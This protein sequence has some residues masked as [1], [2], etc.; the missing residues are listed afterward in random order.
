LTSQ[1]DEMESGIETSAVLSSVTFHKYQ[2]LGNDYI[3]VREADLR[4]PLAPTQIQRI[5]DRHYGFGADGI[6]LDCS[7]P[8][9]EFAARFFNPDGSEAEKSG[10][11]LRIYARYLWD[12]KRVHLEPFT[13]VTAG[14][15]VEAQVHAGG[16]R[17]TVMMG[18][19]CFDS[20]DIPVQGPPREVLDETIRIGDQELT[21]SAVT[22]GNP[23]CVLLRDDLSA[24]E[25]QQWGALLENEPRFP[26]RT[27]VQFMKVLDRG[28]IQIEIWERGAGYT[29]ASGSSSCAAAVVAYRLG[30]CDGGITV[31]MPGGEIEI[32]IDEGYKVSMTGLVAKVWQGNISEEV[33]DN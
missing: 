27:N 1:K 6:L 14:G 7:L 20:R 17:V 29:L 16:R 2:G 21:Y 9:R 3:L 28:N 30:L 19:A 31:H 26:N 12:N 18:P 4:Q 10:N 23:H 32:T 24:K 25:I 11:G 8:Q 15:K 5:C 33:F 22:L 13:I